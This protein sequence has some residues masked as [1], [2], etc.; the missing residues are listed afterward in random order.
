MSPDPRPA[1]MVPERVLRD[2]EDPDPGPAPAGIETLF[3]GQHL[4]KG[5]RGNVVGFVRA[6]NVEPD[7]GIDRLTVRLVP[8]V[9]P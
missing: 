4:E 9:G 3:R 8:G 1:V 2:A 7:V 5:L 6:C